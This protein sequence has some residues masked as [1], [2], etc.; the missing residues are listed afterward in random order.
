M[1]WTE[2]WTSFIWGGQPKKTLTVSSFL[3]PKCLTQL[4]RENATNFPLFHLNGLRIKL[5]DL[6]IL[7]VHLNLKQLGLGITFTSTHFT[8][9]ACKVTHCGRQ[10][11]GLNL[12]WRKPPFVS[13]SYCDTNEWSTTSQNKFCTLFIAICPFHVKIRSGLPS[14]VLFFF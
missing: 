5:Y 10:S 3:I 6:L 4:K 1:T 12:R 7:M 14:V 11:T 9:I 8:T 2:F 13:H